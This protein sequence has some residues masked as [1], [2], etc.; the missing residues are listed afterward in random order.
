MELPEENFYENKSICSNLKFKDN[1]DGEIEENIQELSKSVDILGNYKT[2][3]SRNSKKNGNDL[4]KKKT[5]EKKQ[6]IG[7]WS[8]K[9]FFQLRNY[10]NYLKKHL[11][12][13]LIILLMNNQAG[14]I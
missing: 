8:F 12:E 6:N 4:L 11:N 3:L 14:N 13:N 7:S 10:A 2:S 5:Y 9:N 1:Q